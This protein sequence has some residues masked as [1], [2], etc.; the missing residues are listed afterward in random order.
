MESVFYFY[1]SKVEKVLLHR[2]LLHR[3]GDSCSY[4]VQG[5][6]RDEKQFVGVCRVENCQNS[7][8]EHEKNCYFQ[9]G[10]HKILFID[11]SYIILKI[12]FKLTNLCLA[13]NDSLEAT[14]CAH[15]C[16]IKGNMYP[17]KRPAD[18]ATYEN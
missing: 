18:G 1:S 16:H 3:S 9:C 14:K 7:V 6:P 2:A 10:T 5:C 4:Y 13:Q 8:C 11:F 12:L 15:N 17:K